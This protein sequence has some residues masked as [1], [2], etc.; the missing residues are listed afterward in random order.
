MSPNLQLAALGALAVV[1]IALAGF[2]AFRVVHNNPEKRERRR[3]LHVNQNGRLGDALITE[4]TDALLYYS[5]TVHGVDYSASQDIA[6]LRDRLPAD[7]GRIVGVANLK[8]SPKNPANSIL[9]CEDWS[10]IRASGSPRS[11]A[12]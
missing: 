11:Q 10:G 1:L 2:I 5:Y 9:L 8:Y 4:A 6:A 3:R 7:S 12:S